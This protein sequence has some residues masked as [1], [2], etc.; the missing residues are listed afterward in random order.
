MKKYGKRSIILVLILVSFYPVKSLLE[1]IEKDYNKPVELV[2]SLPFSEQVRQKYNISKNIPIESVFVAGRFS[3]WDVGKKIFELKKVAD[4]SWRLSLKLGKGRHPYKF[5]VIPKGVSLPKWSSNRIWV[6]DKR[7]SVEEDDAFGGKNSIAI[8]RSIDGVRDFL[9]FLFFLFLFGIVA[10]TL[11]EYLFSKLMFVKTSLRYKL[12]IIFLVFLF[13]SDM[14]FIIYGS[15]QRKDMVKYALADKINMIHLFLVNEKIDFGKIDDKKELLKVKVALDNFFKLSSL[16]QNYNDRSNSKQQITS[17]SIVDKKG[18][19]LVDSFELSIKQFLLNTFGNLKVL[20]SFREK[21]IRNSFRE[22]KNSSAYVTSRL[23][24]FNQYD[25]F[26]KQMDKLWPSSDRSRTKV[27]SRYFSS[28]SFYYPIF[29]NQ[30]VVGFYMFTINGESYSSLL[31]EMLHYNML[32]LLFLIFFNFIIIYKIGGMILAPIKQLLSGIN[33][34]R[35]NEFGYDIEISTGD[36]IDELACSYNYMR[37]KIFQTRSELKDYAKN[38]EEKVEERAKELKKAYAHIKED[39]FLAQRIQQNL[40]LKKLPP[41]DMLDIGVSYSPLGEVGGDFYDIFEVRKN[42]IRIFLADATGHGIQAALVTMLIKSEYEQVKTL[43]DPVDIFNM[44][45]HEFLS[46]YGNLTVFFTGI[47]VDIDLDKLTLRYISAGHPG[48]Y[49]IRGGEAICLSNRGKMIGVVTDLAC[50]SH[51]LDLQAKDRV[52]LFTDGVFEQ[53]S[54]SFEEFGL[55][56]L[57]NFLLQKSQGRFMGKSS[58]EINAM[59]VAEVEAFKDVQDRTDDMT[60]ITLN[61]EKVAKKKR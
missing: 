37:K 31:R 27:K 39:L 2:F 51:T 44:L 24:S 47:I 7:A 4:N 28:N 10:L 8:V 19:L 53:F 54:P 55:K 26:D 48:Q 5:V 20:Q 1:K 60:F 45:N 17:I 46:T 59:I 50:S 42:Q 9:Q 16:R 33:K 43:D 13:F 36:E 40:L 49:I 29:E 58:E 14:F 35:N 56:K 18:G 57:R 15:L 22:Y 11:F 30:R 23:F 61:L 41:N 12:V 3:N 34:V 38:L 21:L 52:F 6:K 25:V 32:V